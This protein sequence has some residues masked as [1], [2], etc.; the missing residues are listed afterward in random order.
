MSTRPADRRDVILS[1]AAAAF[2]AHGY[3]ATRLADVADQV[4]ISTPAL[5]RHF[6]TKYG[7]FAATVESLSR[8]VDEVTTSVPVDDDPRVELRAIL[9]AFADMTLTNRAGGNLYRWEDRVLLDAD[10]AHTREVRIRLHRRL[11]TLTTAARPDIDLD[12]ARS[13]TIAALSVVASSATHRAALGR[14]QACRLLTDAAMRVVD[15]DAPADIEPQVSAEGLAPV[16]RRES[17]LAA[18]IAL[19]ADRGFHEVTV[20]DIGAAVGLPAS[21]VYR[22]FPSKNAILAAA[23]WR[24]AD[25]TTDAVAAALARARTPDEALVAL[26]DRYSALCVEEPDVMS[27]YMNGL[28]SVDES[29]LRELRRRQRLTVD[30]WATWVVR[31]HPDTTTAQARFLVH[32]SLNVAT[33][34]VNGHPGVGHPLVSAACARVLG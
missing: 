8:R 11:R 12:T 20:E 27:V 3:A 15:V 2:S 24:T 7:L 5:Y 28:G 22:H 19:F 32:A 18:A 10:R 34:L 21:G 14:R 9:S 16:G 23:L 17:V 25:R 26:A 1:T 13:I 4:G 33:D 29:D 6:D 31:A 30:E